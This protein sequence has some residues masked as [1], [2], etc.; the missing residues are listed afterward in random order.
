VTLVSAT[1]PIQDG[2]LRGDL[3]VKGGGDPFFVS[4][5]ART[6]MHT[7]Y[8]LGLRRVTGSLVIAGDFYMNFTTHPV[9]AGK[10]LKQAFQ[11]GGRPVV[12]KTKSRK[13]ARRVVPAGP[14]IAIAGP[15][16]LVS[17]SPARQT[18][19]IRH[20]SQPLV[21]LLKRM[22]VYSSNVMASMF[23]AALGGTLQMVQQA[24]LATGV[25]MEDI[26]LINGSGLGA[27]NQ[28]SPRTVCAMFMAIQYVLRPA[29]LTIAD[30]FP[31][32]GRDHGTIRRRHLPDAT[33]V[34][35]GTLRH[36]ST[37]A[38]VMLTREHGPVWFALIN[39]GGNVSGF[40]AQ[41]DILL[42][43]L[44]YSWG[45]VYP[46]PEDFAPGHLWMETAQDD[47]LDVSQGARKVGIMLAK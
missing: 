35:T 12:I 23:T 40:R 46:P 28:L 45:A 10:V 43:N 25:P 11:A 20:R 7:L 1:G 29:R 3:V 27:E 38:G 8:G 37:L 16:E 17:V 4:E 39:R 21:Q 2:V 42:Q 44:M 41:Q 13:G 5:D 19:L 22:N 47:V 18:P 24:A 36:V 30:V 15:V 9:L 33:V 32:A 34:K 14:H 31:V 6:L 26:H